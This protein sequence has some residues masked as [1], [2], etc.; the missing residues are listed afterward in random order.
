VF[1]SLLIPQIKNEK[2]SL[3]KFLKD[4]SRDTDERVVAFGT[5]AEE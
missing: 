1:L 4:Q 2:F 3:I 5:L